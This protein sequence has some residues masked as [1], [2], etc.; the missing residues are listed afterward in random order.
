MVCI[1]VFT[2]MCV[3]WTSASR[4]GAYSRYLQVHFGNLT[5]VTAVQLEHPTYVASA[6]QQY[7]VHYSGDGINW[8]AGPTVS[9]YCNRLR[10]SMLFN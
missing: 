2:F 9:S 3:G 10:L 5:R 7:Q 1:R 8:N 4:L 6:V